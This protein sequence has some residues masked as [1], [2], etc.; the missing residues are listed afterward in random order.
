M[1][2][3]GSGSSD[4]LAAECPVPKFASMQD[5]SPEAIRLVEESAPDFIVA[6]AHAKEIAE[7]KHTPAK[8]N[9]TLNAFEDDPILLYACLWY[10]CSHDVTVCFY[11][12]SGALQRRRIE[13]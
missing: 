1:S 9:L 6:V 13:L 12:R 2:K 3:R 7:R 4:S 5:I 10:A 8:L 11:L